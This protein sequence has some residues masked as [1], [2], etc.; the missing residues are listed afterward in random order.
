MSAE[1]GIAMED[2]SLLPGTTLDTDEYERMVGEEIIHPETTGMNVDY[3]TLMD[4][5]QNLGVDPVSAAKFAC[6]I[7]R[8]KPS[9]MEMYGERQHRRC[10][11]PSLPRPQSSWEAS[12]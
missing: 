5:L 2:T 4:T 12:I 11:Q 6:S 3:L 10:C 8:S 7:V 9:V 1:D